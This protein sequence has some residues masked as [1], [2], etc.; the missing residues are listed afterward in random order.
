[1]STLTGQTNMVKRQ[2]LAAEE[3]HEG[4]VRLLLGRK[5]LKPDMADAYGRTPLLC[6]SAIWREEVVKLLVEREDVNIHKPDND[7]QTVLLSA[8]ERGSAGWWGFYWD[9]KISTSTHAGKPVRNYSRWLRR[10][11]MME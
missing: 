6:A 10:R 1:M 4:V 8:V 11:D 9:G 3:G 5:D 7:G 2:L